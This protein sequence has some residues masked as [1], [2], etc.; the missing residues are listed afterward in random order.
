MKVKVTYYDTYDERGEIQEMFIDEKFVA[1]S[2]GGEPED[3]IIGRDLLSLTTVCS[4]MKRAYDAG[5]NGEELEYHTEE[6]K[7]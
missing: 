2:G 4:L 7:P 1:R 3:M 5:K 6:A